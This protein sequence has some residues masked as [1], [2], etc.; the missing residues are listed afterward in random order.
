MPVKLF[1]L[2]LAG[3]LLTIGAWAE[4]YTVRIH[5]AK[6]PARDVLRVYEKLSAHPVFMALDLDA[7]VTIESEKEIAPA[8]AMELIRKT[9]LERY[10]IE[11][12]KTDAGETL[13]GWSKD[14]K[15]P[16]GSDGPLTEKE[17]KAEPKS[18]PRAPQP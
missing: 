16:R 15:Y 6:A 7:L 12:R 4:D 9:L 8:E 10:G 13:A 5:Y 11:L 1:A 17:R 3:S 2:I 18:Q 14:P